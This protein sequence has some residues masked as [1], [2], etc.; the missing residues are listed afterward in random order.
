MNTYFPDPI[1]H[2]VVLLEACKTIEAAR[3]AACINAEHAAT[4]REFRYWSTVRQALTEKPCAAT[5]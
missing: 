2:A 1:E 5:N 3:E 4:D